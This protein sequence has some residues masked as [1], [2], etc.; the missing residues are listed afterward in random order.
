MTRDRLDQEISR[1]VQA[2]ERDVPPRLDRAF[3]EAL[4]HVEPGPAQRSSAPRPVLFKVA[5]AAATVLLVSV[6]ILFYL[7]YQQAGPAPDVIVEAEE[8]WLQ[9][10]YV[11]GEPAA[12]YTVN[13]KEG[14]MTIVWVEKIKN[15]KGE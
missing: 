13:P 3:H 9:E 6:M 12:T 5:L 4:R 1:L 10:T 15:I 2:Q 11:E 14:D 8:V 7:F